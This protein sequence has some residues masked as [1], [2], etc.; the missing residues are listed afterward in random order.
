[1]SKYV[2]KKVGTMADRR[3]KL[4][5]EQYDEIKDLYYAGESQRH[6]SNKFGV[7]RT[8]IS[9]ILFP[10]RDKKRLKRNKNR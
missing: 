5:P 7:S 2:A 3:R 10:E 8:C 4:T 9:F 1:M 6:L